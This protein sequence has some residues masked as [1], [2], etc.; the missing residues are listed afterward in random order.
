MVEVRQTAE[1][2][3]WLHRLKNSEALRESSLVCAAWNRAIL[4]MQ[5]ALDEA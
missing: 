1:F 3:R 4:A 2:A 5:R